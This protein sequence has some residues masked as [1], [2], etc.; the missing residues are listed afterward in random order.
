MCKTILNI[1]VIIYGEYLIYNGDRVDLLS[2][3]YGSAQ[4]FK[5]VLNYLPAYLPQ[6]T[7]FHNV[8]T[9][10]SLG[11]H[12]AYRLASMSPGQFEG[13]AIVV[14]CPTLAPLLLSRL[15]IDSA[16][17]GTTTAELGSVSFDRLEQVMDES[18]KRRWPRQI[19]KLIHDGDEKVYEEFPTDVP[20]LLCNGKHDTL[21][22]ASYTAL[23]LRKRHANGLAPEPNKNLKFF[24]QEN[25]GHS[26]TK[27]MVAMIAS[28]IGNMFESRD[29]NSNAPIE[30]HL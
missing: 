27:E 23:W 20:V 30:S 6:F 12:T 15:G 19:A 2:V 21:V 13:F 8:L 28:W 16:T 10:I 26:C 29:T 24:V 18:Q 5:L 4:D 25:T 7:H 17:L 1:R 11:G 14:G 3:I 22:P 9:G